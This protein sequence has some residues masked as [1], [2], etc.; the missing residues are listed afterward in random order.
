VPVFKDAGAEHDNEASEAS[1]TRAARR[2]CQ[3]SLPW[4][5]SFGSSLLSTRPTCQRRQQMPVNFLTISR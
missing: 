4:K 5:P 3:Q 1:R 2:G